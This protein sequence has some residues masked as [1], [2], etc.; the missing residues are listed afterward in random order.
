M[1]WW[2]VQGVQGVLLPSDSWDRFEQLLFL[3]TALISKLVNLTD[4][5][6]LWSH[7]KQA[8]GQWGSLAH[9]QPGPSQ[10]WAWAPNALEIAS[11]WVLLL[12]LSPFSLGCVTALVLY[13]WNVW[14]WLVQQMKQLN[15][16]VWFPRGPPGFMGCRCLQRRRRAFKAYQCQL[17]RALF[18]F[19]GSH[20]GR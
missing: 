9:P 15:A 19:Y 8:G 14:L 6:T 12:P 4:F 3:N 18:V 13:Y 20:Q 17:L 2:P 10:H 7:E 1:E 16:N 11:H 5:N